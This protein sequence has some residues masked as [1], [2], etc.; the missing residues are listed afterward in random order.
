M[1]VRKYVIA[2]IAGSSIVCTFITFAYLAHGHIKSGRAKDV[3]YE[4]F[5][6]AVPIAYGIASVFLIHFGGSLKAAAMTGALLG[7][8]LSTGGRMQGLPT[9]LFGFTK[10]TEANV[11]PIAAVLYSLIFVTV[12]R[13]VTLYCVG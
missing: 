3:P 2:F 1:D 9:K 5:A 8:A 13:P 12:V 11:H 4:M 10:D 7:L 6:F